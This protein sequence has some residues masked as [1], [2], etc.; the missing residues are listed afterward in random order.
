MIVDTVEARTVKKYKN[1]N[2][3]FNAHS[4]VTVLSIFSPRFYDYLTPKGS[5]QTRFP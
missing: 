1:L 5:T 2:F 4:L 3:L